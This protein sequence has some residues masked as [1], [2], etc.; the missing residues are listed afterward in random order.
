MPGDLVKID[1]GN[2]LLDSTLQLFDSGSAAQAIHYLGSTNAAGTVL[3]RND[4]GHDGIYLLDT[5]H[6]RLENLR[7]TGATIGIRVD[8][9]SSA[10]VDGIEVVGCE[11]YGN[12]WGINSALSLKPLHQRPHAEQ[13]AA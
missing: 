9:S 3:D 10:P 11:L 5:H 8:S 6:V 13:S 4:T 1:T 2:Y 7:V 12:G